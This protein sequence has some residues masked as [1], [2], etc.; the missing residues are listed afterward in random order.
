MQTGGRVES[1]TWEHFNQVA[2]AVGYMSAAGAAVWGILRTF[3]PYLLRVAEWLAKSSP[4]NIDRID[5]QVEKVRAKTHLILNLHGDAVYQCTPDGANFFV[6][7]PLAEM[8]GV[9]VDEMHGNGWA[10]RIVREDRMRELQHWRDCVDRNVPYR[11]KYTIEVNGAR[12][13]IETEARPYLNHE[14]RVL[15]WIGWARDCGLIVQA[16]A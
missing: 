13:L 12:K 3:R 2:A 1:F 9:D 10:G 6:S 16:E 4:S 8:F 11:T 14:G 5:S 15:F 7:E